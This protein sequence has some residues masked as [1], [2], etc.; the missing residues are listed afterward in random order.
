MA[1]QAYSRSLQGNQ[2]LSTHFRVLDFACKDGSDYLLVDSE[3]V[4]ILQAIRNYLG[5]AITIASGYRNVE[6]NRRINGAVGSLHT[7]G[8]AADIH[9]NGYDSLAV[10]RAAE[11][12]GVLGIGHYPSFTHVDSRT[13]KS[14]WYD[15]SWE[16][17]STFGGVF[18]SQDR[19]TWAGYFGQVISPNVPPPP[20][21]AW[22]VNN[23]YLSQA[24]YENNCQLFC[25]YMLGRGFTFNAICGMLGNI[26]I[27]SRCN[28]G[29]WEN[30]TPW[31]PNVGSRGVGLNQWTPYTGLTDDWVNHFGGPWDSPEVQ[32]ELICAECF[33]NFGGQWGPWASG[34][35]QWI[36]DDYLTFPEFAASNLPPDILAQY[37]IWLYLR[38]ADK[39]Q[40]ARWAEANRLAGNLSASAGYP[41][42][43]PEP[44]WIR[45]MQKRR[46]LYY[47]DAYYMK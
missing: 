1:V 28:P 46:W 27:E 24:D 42:P 18:G 21:A 17:R 26:Y 43:A 34:I 33:E 12:M 2:M 45:Q 5:A 13:W 29:M 38:P 4:V 19:Y 20:G 41:V 16:Y 37:Y 10:A 8:Q 23:T 22:V 3:L 44:D 47:L 30:L 7:L 11:E 32:M 25:S 6:Y 15:H 39:N 14:Y 9:V 36:L 40:P 31:P 35:P